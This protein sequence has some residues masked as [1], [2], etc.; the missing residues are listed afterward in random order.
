[1][2]H[3]SIHRHSFRAQTSTHAKKLE[4]SADQGPGVVVLATTVQHHTVEA[5]DYL[6][7][8]SEPEPSALEYPELG[9]LRSMAAQAFYNL[10]DSVSPEPPVAQKVSVA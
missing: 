6:Q 5:L 3:T 7:H 10:K 9:E 8:A 2:S 4:P 1:M